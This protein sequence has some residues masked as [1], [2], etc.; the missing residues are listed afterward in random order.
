M[1]SFLYGA[2]SYGNNASVDPISEYLKF[3][4]KDS[5]WFSVGSQRKWNSEKVTAVIELAGYGLKTECQSII[6]MFL[7]QY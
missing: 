5:E 6:C 3:H 1:L 4:L 2:K 7:I